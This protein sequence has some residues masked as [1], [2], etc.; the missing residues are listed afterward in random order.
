MPGGRGPWILA[1]Q[2]ALV[3]SGWASLVQQGLF[4]NHIYE[5]EG[6]PYASAAADVNADGRADL[7]VG[8]DWSTPVAAILL[9][10]TTG[11]L[12]DPYT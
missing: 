9:A 7:I 1:A 11:S 6:R 12:A 8:M 10:T 4:P 2:L 5:L 3:S